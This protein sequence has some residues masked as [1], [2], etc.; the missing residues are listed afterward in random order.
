MSLRQQQPQTESKAQSS[1]SAHQDPD[2]AKV[3]ALVEAWCAASEAGDLDALL[4]LMTDDILFL[5]PANPPMTRAAFIAGFSAMQGKVRIACHSNI[6]EI[7]IDGPLAILRNQLVV[8][9]HPLSGG[10]PIRHA[11]D[12]LSVLR[13]GPDGQWRLWRDANLLTKTN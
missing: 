5:T 12:V 3:R 7:T 8:E 9:I 4:P 6:Q 2:T 10:D 1:N 13:R 11:G